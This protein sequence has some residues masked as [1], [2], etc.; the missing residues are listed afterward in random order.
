MILRVSSSLSQRSASA[1][2]RSSR[3]KSAIIIRSNERRRIV[4]FIQP[5]TTFYLDCEHRSLDD[6]TSL[7]RGTEHKLA[8]DSRSRHEQKQGGKRKSRGI[9]SI[10]YVK[11][12]RWRWRS[13][14]G[15]F[16]SLFEEGKSSSFAKNHFMA[17]CYKKV[18]ID[19]CETTRSFKPSQP[20][21]L[22]SLTVKLQF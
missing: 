13:L 18:Q 11:R 3:H 19:F 16:R 6:F 7:H 9:E 12:E 14:N 10:I 1:S 2:C 17:S 4:L 21:L 15:S 5:R 8:Y 20:Q 22:G